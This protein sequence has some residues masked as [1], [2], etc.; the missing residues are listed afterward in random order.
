MTHNYSIV[1]GDE[2]RMMPAKNDDEAMRLASALFQNLPA[3]SWVKTTG[4]FC[5]VLTWTAS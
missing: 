2:K 4:K 3:G 1:V 5:F